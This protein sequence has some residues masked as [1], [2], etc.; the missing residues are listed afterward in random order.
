[1]GVRWDGTMGGEVGQNQGGSKV[2]W[3]HGGGGGR[4]DGTRVGVR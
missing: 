4:W 2:G 1:M 3:N